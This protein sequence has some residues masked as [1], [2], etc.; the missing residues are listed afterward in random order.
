MV[1]P[2][3]FQNL[4]IIIHKNHV[5]GFDG[6]AIDAVTHYWRPSCRYSLRLHDRLSVL[7][8]SRISTLLNGLTT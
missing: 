4:R 7:N 8:T 3:Y 1:L 5:F 2:D 6:Q